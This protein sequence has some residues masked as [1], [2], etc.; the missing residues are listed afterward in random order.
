[1]KPPGRRLPPNMGNSYGIEPNPCDRTFRNEAKLNA[2][3]G[4][5]AFV[6]ELGFQVFKTA[7]VGDPIRQLSRLPFIG[8]V[9][10]WH[11]EGLAR[12]S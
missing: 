1:M 11:E 5:A 7:V 8:P 3:L 10:V 12:P 4:V 2:I 6:H 9:T